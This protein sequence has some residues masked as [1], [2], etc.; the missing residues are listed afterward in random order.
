MVDCLR[1]NVEVTGAARNYRAAFGG[2]QGYTSWD[3]HGNNYFTFGSGP[4]PLSVPW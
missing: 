4:A 3:I 1:H 2:P